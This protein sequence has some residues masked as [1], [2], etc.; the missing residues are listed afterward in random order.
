MGCAPAV[1][2]SLIH[3]ANVGAA[4]N[5]PNNENHISMTAVIDVSH[6]REVA[7][8]ITRARREKHRFSIAHS[9][10]RIAKRHSVSLRTLYSWEK[11]AK[12]G[13]L[14]RRIGSGRHKKVT[15]TIEAWFRTAAAERRG[16]WTIQD[17]VSIMKAKFG[18]GSP[19][20]VVLL[21]RRLGFGRV[22][23]GS[24]PILTEAHKAARLA[25]CSE[26]SSRVQ[27]FG[28]NNSVFIHVDE[29]W[30]DG[31][32]LGQRIWIDGDAVRPRIPVQS[33]SFIRKVMFLAAVGKPI[34]GKFNGAIGLYPLA[35]IVPAA[36]A[37]SHRP[38]GAP[39]L[40]LF[41]MDKEMFIKMLKENVVRDALQTCPWA[42]EITIQMDNAGGHGGGRGGKIK[43]T[44]STLNAWASNLP[45]E[46]LA[47]LHDPESPP[48]IHFIAQP[49]CSPDL[50]VL[51][52]GAWRS[53]DI[54]VDKVKRNSFLR[55]LD[56]MEIY[57]A[58][59]DAWISWQSADKL[60]KLFD[61]LQAV[62][63]CIIDNDG[64]NNFLLPHK[65]IMKLH[66]ENGKKIPRKA[67]IE[68]RTWQIPMKK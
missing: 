27:P 42:R 50:N 35:K 58:A 18:F 46:Y 17:M 52:L 5:P 31:L 47:L 33:K 19:R 38:A 44:L 60:D 53:M 6:A 9:L 14:W 16:T 54:A 67:R 20:T 43:D 28:D 11:R 23:L 62:W 48:K 51:D 65:K 39:V 26:Q 37:S 40:K 12:S 10:L 25:W 2:I 64:S 29:K 13:G 32:H 22:A 15:N 4:K 61:T 8:G 55:Q 56:E 7:E 57:D 66:F 36:R 41:S 34:P 24:A 1:R 30:F 59:R 49:S 63:R 21:A 45:Q 3:H 68:P